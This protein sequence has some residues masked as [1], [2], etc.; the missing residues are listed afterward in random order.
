[1]IYPPIGGYFLRLIIEKSQKF[2]HGCYVCF[3]ILSKSIY[4]NKFVVHYL[5]NLCENI[6]ELSDEHNLD[7]CTFG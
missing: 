1:M 3:Y 4:L 7:V 6:E 2:S 5:I